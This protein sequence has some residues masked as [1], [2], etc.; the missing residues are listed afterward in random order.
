MGPPTK[1]VISFGPF[2]LIAGERVLTRDGTLV[3]LGARALDT[4]IVLVSC[5]NEVVTKRD[6]LARV[7][8]DVIVDE[9]SLRFHI[10][11]LRKALGDGEEGSRYIATIA[12]R[13]YCFVAPVSRS[14]QA[15]RS[16]SDTASTN[17]TNPALPSRLTRM[18][19]R[20]EE[21]RQIAAHLAELRFVTI[22]GAGGVGK[23][24]VAVSVAHDLFQSFDGAVAFIDL[25]AL[26]EAALVAPT[27]ATMLGVSTDDAVSSLIAYLRDKR[28]LLVLDTCEHLIEAVAGL[29]SR[30]FVA[31]LQLHLLITSRESLRVEGEHVYRL[32]PLACPPDELEPTAAAVQAFPA[33]QLFLERAAASGSRLS[34]GDAE[35]AIVAGICRKLDGVALAIELA[36]GRVEA[37]GLKRTAALLDERLTLQW[38]GRRTAPPRQKTLQATLEWSYGLLSELERDVLRR[39]AIF[40]GQFT[41]E[42]ALEVV[43]YSP[44]DEGRVLSAIDSLVA[45]SMVAA[46]PGVTVMRYRL[47]EATR[48]Y[49]LAVHTDAAD[50]VDL[51]MRHAKYFQRWLD[52]TG[53]EWPSLSSGAE[54]ASR[55]ADL[56]EVRA[57]L[58]W[59]FGTH[60]NVHVGI[61]LAASA[62]R[63]LWTMSIYAE[64][65][66]WAETAVLAIDDGTRG[67]A[68]EM[69]IQGALGMALMFESRNEVALAAL[70]R[71]LAIAKSI[72]EIQQQR[73]LLTPLLFFHTR[74]REFNTA[75]GYA[76]DG[77]ELAVRHGGSTDL[78]LART[79][80]GISLHFTGDF[81]GA[82][83]E[84]ES[85]L[86]GDPDAQWAN[87]VFLTSGHR[88]WAGTALA[89]TLWLQG[90]PA[91]AVEGILQ[92]IETA[93]KLDESLGLALHWGLAVF[94]WAG[95]I[96]RAKYHVDW[97]VSR[98][99][100]FGVRHSVT[101]GHSMRAA[102]AIQRGEVKDGIEGLQRC[103]E[104]LH[105]DT[106][107]L[108]TE[109]HMALI[110]GFIATG[111]F[112][113]ALR[114]A[115]DSIGR[116][117]AGG[118][119]CYLPELL[120]LKGK[121]L[122]ATPK[123]ADDGE[124]QLQRS[125]ELSRQQGALAWELRT[126]IDLAALKADQGRSGDAR[127][128]LRPVFS[129]FTEGTDTTDLRL[130]QDLLATLD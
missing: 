35:A 28:M 80:K 115:D 43:T 86:R 97:F 92:T 68:E 109:T 11:S 47:L 44:L 93:A 103:L 100:K 5:P 36:A 18:V 54:R 70:N 30:L 51:P 101:I 55:V 12:G 39:L 75:L 57:A 78:A 110:Q 83:T 88:I 26:T 31:G 4:L 105:P 37:Y 38:P 91:Q 25:S 56:V 58:E 126:A 87:P 9:G 71:S 96:D 90:Y 102:L 63:V 73:R 113:E 106:F 121:A 49:V 124:T 104:K 2:R 33:A 65:R 20:V 84:L 24:T 53:A 3:E 13:G 94:L 120:R 41:L 95:D 19:G 59:C 128:I 8:P 50:L 10:A 17:L 29:T 22:V 130:A 23:T 27:I 114:L 60:G 46:R 127:E 45:K 119:L 108:H 66:R 116:V 16:P 99:E 118:D 125:L 98:S 122:L 42:A 6:L 72:G 15:Q 7:W 69:H 89:R 14:Q 81:G 32:D 76:S 77:V 67:T 107:E 40:V 111:R 82:R 48:A 64:C 117:E 123:R 79:L 21:T 34:F 1:D 85:A 129:R 52:A 112:A 74:N 61:A 62:T